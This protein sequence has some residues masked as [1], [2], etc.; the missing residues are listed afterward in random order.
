MHTT[1]RSIDDVSSSNLEG[2]DRHSQ[3]ALSNLEGTASFKRSMNCQSK[4][5]PSG[6]QNNPNAALGTYEAFLV[7]LGK[8]KALLL[9]IHAPITLH[10]TY[11]IQSLAR[12]TFEAKTSKDG[13][14]FHC[15]PP[16][17][18]FVAV[19]PFNEE[20]GAAS[21]KRGVNLPI[22]NTTDFG[23]FT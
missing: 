6:Q 2:W 7:G 11:H 15:L 5:T 16:A 20:E 8:K 1:H 14:S 10:R 18:R 17:E 19:A 23:I 3:L 12:S 22:K 13:T 21:L 4:I 9:F